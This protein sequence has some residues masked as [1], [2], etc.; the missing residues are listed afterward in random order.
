MNRNKI[1]SLLGFLLFIFSVLFVVG[2]NC[3]HRPGA[4]LEGDA[5]SDYAPAIETEQLTN[6]HS[7][8]FLKECIM[9]KHLVGYMDF[10]PSGLEVLCIV[11]Y[12][13]ALVIISS[14]VFLFRFFQCKYG[15]GNLFSIFC[16]F[17]FLINSRASICYLYMDFYFLGA[18]M[19]A[20]SIL[21]LLFCNKRNAC[22]KCLLVILLV[23]TLYQMVELRKNS[24]LLLP[25]LLCIATKLLFPA[26]NKLKLLISGAIASVCLFVVYAFLTN[27]ICQPERTH[28][29][30]VM[31]MS[32]I[33]LASSL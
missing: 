13:N 27:L 28:P 26:I 9:L 7:A 16:A 24:V 23:L 4:I 2:V 3:P 15:L 22:I 17:L 1:I 25:L 33:C 6:W 31:M 18:L 10:Y 14:T 29:A 19:V 12:L 5:V 20:V 30:S 8:L 11:W 21:L 32:D